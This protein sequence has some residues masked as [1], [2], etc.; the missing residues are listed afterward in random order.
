MTCVVVVVTECVCACDFC[1]DIILQ[2]SDDDDVDVDVDGD[3][4]AHRILRAPTHGLIRATP[5]RTSADGDW[6]VRR[7]ATPKAGVS[8]CTAGANLF[9]ALMM[10]ANARS[11]TPNDALTRDSRYACDAYAQR[12]TRRTVERSSDGLAAAAKCRLRCVGAPRLR[13]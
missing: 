12:R 6:H 10:V 7:G 4:D 9:N 11:V 5:A 1:R 2:R 3:G 8:V 13:L